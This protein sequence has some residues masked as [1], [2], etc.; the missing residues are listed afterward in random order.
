MVSLTDSPTYAEEEVG[1]RS[2]HNGMRDVGPFKAGEND[3]KPE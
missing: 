2:K 3:C 1:Q